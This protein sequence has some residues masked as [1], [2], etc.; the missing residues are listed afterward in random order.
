MEARGPRS[1]VEFDESAIG[2]LGALNAIVAS[3]VPDFREAFR[4]AAAEARRVIPFDAIGVTQVTGESARE[5]ICVV[6]HATDSFLEGVRAEL[7]QRCWLEGAVPGSKVESEVI[8]L[9]GV[10]GADTA[11][12]VE[13]YETCGAQEPARH[14]VGVFSSA[15]NAFT[16]KHAV[17]LTLFSNWLRSYNTCSAAY[18]QMEEASLTDPLCGCHNRRKFDQEL[19]RE[20]ERARRYGQVLCVAIIDVDHLKVINDT[21]GHATGDIVLKTVADTFSRKLRRVDL[22]A[23]YGG[24]EFV[25][26]LPHTPIQG[27]IIALSRVLAA[28]HDTIVARRE[29]GPEV[30]ASVGVAMYRPGED[31]ASLLKRADEA[32]Y[33]AKK[34]SRGTVVAA[35]A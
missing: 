10:H 3:D 19:P 30:T 20:V 17:L 32:L 15:P 16:R 4:R 23:R 21:L 28:C 2:F 26:I 8:A 11:Q 13:S 29:G 7:M 6:G 24:D 25:A 14:C 35:D 34:D 33:Q 18:R 12:R 9:P 5:L 27:A 31:A 22:F 1:S